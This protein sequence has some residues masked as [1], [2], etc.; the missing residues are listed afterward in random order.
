M[1]NE[2][3]MDDLPNHIGELKDIIWIQR[4]ELFALRKKQQVKTNPPYK[5]SISFNKN[6]KKS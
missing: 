1:E 6:K 3:F 4:E 5:I 2:D